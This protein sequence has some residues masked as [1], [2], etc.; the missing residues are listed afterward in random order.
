M[1][2]RVET[3]LL[4]HGQG[5]SILVHVGMNNA[6]REGTTEIVYRYRQLVGKLN[7]TRAEQIILPGI[8]SVMGG[9]GATYIIYKRMTINALVQQMFEKE[10]VGII[11]LWGNVFGKKTCALEMASI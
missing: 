11:D 8:L 2:E 6:D 3:I 10:G 4:G 9:R 7:K 1:T 5:G